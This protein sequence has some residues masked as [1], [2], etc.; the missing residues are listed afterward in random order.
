[1]KE[2]QQQ[3][4]KVGGKKRCLQ[5]GRKTVTKEKKENRRLYN[6]VG[7]GYILME[8]VGYFLVN[9]MFIHRK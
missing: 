8:M 1:M 4:R 7:K 3:P 2:A 9:G 6:G 5:Y